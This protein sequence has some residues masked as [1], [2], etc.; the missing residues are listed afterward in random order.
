MTPLLLIFILVLIV[1]AFVFLANSIISLKQKAAETLAD[2]DVQLRRRHDLIPNLI[3]TVQGYAAH[4]KEIF[5]ETATI[6][7]QALNANTLSDKSSIEEKLR[8]NVNKILA[9]GE[10]YPDLKANENFL[11]LQKQ[12]VTTEDEIASARRIYNDAVAS[13]NIRISTFPGSV[14]APLLKIQ[15]ADFFQNPV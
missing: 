5:E 11:Q 14:I 13:L 8:Q 2:I 9:I 15:K 12:L 4:E 1:V 7:S 10:A 6:R 3:T